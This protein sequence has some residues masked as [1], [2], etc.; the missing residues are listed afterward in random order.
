MKK[1]TLI[2]TFGLASIISF[3]GCHKKPVGLTSLPGQ[4]GPSITG[5]G[6]ENSGKLETP[7]VSESGIPMSSESNNPYAKLWNGQGTEN[8][9][10]FAA[11]TVHFKTDGATIEQGDRAKLDDVAN[12]FKSNTTDALNIE[13]NCDERGT[14]QYNLS[15][16]DKRA[17]AVREY[18]ANLGVD[19]QRL[20]TVS[21]GE[22]KPVAT[23]HDEAAWHKNRRA[24][25]VL[26]QPK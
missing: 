1:T 8:R 6:V 23:G 2:L 24:E 26:L 22:A 3:T 5:P 16:G 12:Y 21:Y 19:P 11:D 9:D 7:H 17:L 4:S 14:E 20:H 25:L 13:G 18:L 10:K 15:L